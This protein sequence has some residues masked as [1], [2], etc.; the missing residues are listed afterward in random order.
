MKIFKWVT[1]DTNIDFLKYRK[2]AYAFSIIMCV[3]SVWSIAFNGFNYGIDFSGGILIEVKSA[4][5]I[6][7]E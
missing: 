1:K 5:K 7:V 4:N 2:L 3:I 6:N